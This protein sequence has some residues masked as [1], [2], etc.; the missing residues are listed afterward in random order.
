MKALSLFVLESCERVLKPLPIQLARLRRN[1]ATKEGGQEGLM[2]V[3]RRAA[4][5]AARG[6]ECFEAAEGSLCGLAMVP[7]FQILL[8][9][10][11]GC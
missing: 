10:E 9:G 4:W 2:R 5:I 8:S 1:W 6:V 7:K 11:V 3:A